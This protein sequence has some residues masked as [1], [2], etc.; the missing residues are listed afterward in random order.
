MYKYQTVI[1]FRQTDSAGIIFFASLFDLAHDC[2]ES[3]LDPDFSLASVIGQGEILMPIVHAEADYNSPIKLGDKF[4]IEMNLNKTGTSS[5]ELGYAFRNE[6]AKIAAEVRITH[7]VLQ[8]N[9][10][11]PIEIPHTLKSVL[12]KLK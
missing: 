6:S 9:T 11:K 5:F 8:T 4:T 2:Y 1:R 7:V 12:S 10:W 3:F